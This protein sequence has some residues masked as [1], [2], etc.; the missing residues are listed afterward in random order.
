VL[1]GITLCALSAAPAYAANLCVTDGATPGK[2]GD[3]TAKASARFLDAASKAFLVFRALELGEDFR[4]YA[5]EAATLLD[6]AVAGYQQ[7]LALDGEVR[8]ADSF[9]RERPWERLRRSLGVTPGT[10]NHVRWEIIEKTARES[11][12]PTADLVFVCTAGAG[13]LKNLLASITPGMNRVL[14]RKVASTWY[15]VLSH[16]ALISDA[17]DASV[18]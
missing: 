17:F 9:L 6:A 14:L 13:Q 8:A 2:L 18:Q 3:V 4:P 12:T 5:S 7:A 16:G 11:K 10:L 15:A 1:L